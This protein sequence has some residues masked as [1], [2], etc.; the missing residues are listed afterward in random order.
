LMIFPFIAPPAL[1]KIHGVELSQTFLESL[2]EHNIQI[3]EQGFITR[4]G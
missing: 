4:M 3:M 2:V 1:L